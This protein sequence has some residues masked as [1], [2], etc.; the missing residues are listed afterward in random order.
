MDE[1]QTPRPTIVSS[2]A[3]A[4]HRECPRSWA[5]AYPLGLRRTKGEDW[6]P[7]AGVAH[8]GNAYHS[9]VSAWYDGEPIVPAI[10]RWLGDDWLRQGMADRDGW[11]D[12]KDWVSSRDYA[13]VMAEGYPEFIEESGHDEGLIILANEVHWMVERN[14]LVVTGTWDIVAWDVLRGGIVLRDHKSVKGLNDGLTLPSDP[15]LRTYAWALWIFFGVVPV[16]AHHLRARRIKSRARAVPPFYSRPLSIPVTQEI[17]DTH[18]KLLHHRVYLMESATPVTLKGLRTEP[19]IAPNPG[20]YCDWKCNY[21]DLCEE[22]DTTD[23]YEEIIEDEFT[24]SR[25]TR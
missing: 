24:T 5:L 11:R 21:R 6:V 8:T 3:L 14:G 19:E 1:I 2:S 22:I 4:S 15:Q 20:R 13:V 7:K 23:Y 9:G 10:E 18:E 17:L 12:R 25:P 16:D